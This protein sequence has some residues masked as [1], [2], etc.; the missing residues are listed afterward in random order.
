MDKRAR[1]SGK[2]GPKEEPKEDR[3][4]ARS[5]QALSQAF[6]SLLREKPYAR[7]SI[8]EIAERAN[9]GRSTFYEH[10]E[11]K[12]QLMLWGHDHLKDLVLGEAGPSPTGAPRLRFLG[13][14]RHLAESPELARAVGRGPAGEIVSGFLRDTLRRNL[15]AQAAQT[16]RASGSAGPGEKPRRA[17]IAWSSEAAAAGLVAV[18]WRWVRDGMREPP[19]AMAAFCDAFLERVFAE[20]GKA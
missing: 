9:V 14:Y 7:I 1:S 15:E 19:E 5:R 18:L 16:V 10:F 20:D 12:E 6:V 2:N 8:Q 13:L 4:R 11:N 17:R 3:R